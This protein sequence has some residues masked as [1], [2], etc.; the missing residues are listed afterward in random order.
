MKRIYLSLMLAAAALAVVGLQTSSAAV[1]PDTNLPQIQRPADDGTDGEAP[2]QLASFLQ[3]VMNDVNDSWA[4]KFQAAG[5]PYQPAQLRLYQG[6]VDSACGATDGSV[7]PFYC[8]ADQTVYLGLDF[9]QVM[10]QNLGATG[11]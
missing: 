9:F 2:D 5:R 3:G 1:A 7:G 4:R 11:D 10:E 8:P 6:G